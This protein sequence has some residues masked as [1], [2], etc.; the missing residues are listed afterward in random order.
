M[1]TKLGRLAPP[2]PCERHLNALCKSDELFGEVG[3]SAA[4]NRKLH[5]E[6]FEAADNCRKDILDRRLLCIHSEE[7]DFRRYPLRDGLRSAP[8]RRKYHKIVG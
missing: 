6:L 8:L 4:D 7:V 1:G 5:R 3:G 2:G